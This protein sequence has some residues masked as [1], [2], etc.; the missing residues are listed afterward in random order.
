[1]ELPLIDEDR[2]GDLGDQI[3]VARHGCSLLGWFCD[4]TVVTR[5]VA[6]VVLPTP[7]APSRAMAAK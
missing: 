4:N 5:W 6:V 2:A 7:L 1:L 3:Q